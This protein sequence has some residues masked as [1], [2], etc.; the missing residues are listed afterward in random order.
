[1]KRAGRQQRGSDL[2]NLNLAFH[3]VIRNAAGNRYLDRSLTQMENTVRRFRP[4]TSVLPG[5]TSE[6]IQEHVELAKAIVDGDAVTAERLA[7]EHMRR[8]AELRLRMLIEG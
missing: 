7:I 1:M 4:G 3:R 6:S 2:A 8:L 5:R